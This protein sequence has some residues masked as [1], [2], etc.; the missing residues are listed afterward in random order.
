M[1]FDTAIIGAGPA[2]MQAACD[3]RARELSVIVLDEQP[4]PGGQ[5]WRGVERNC[6]PGS[7][8][9]QRLGAEYR[10][11]AGVARSFRAC[12]A[13]YRPLSRVWQIE[14]TGP[15]AT[16]Q[17]WQ[18]FVIRE[19]QAEVVEA[20]RVLLAIGAQERPVPFPGWTH[21][22]V[23]TVG[24]AQIMLKSGG[25][26]PEGPVWICG[27]GPLPLLYAHQLR[28]LGGQIAGFLDTA[29]RDTV[30]RG[31][32]HLS[33][34]LRDWKSLAKGLAWQA[35]LRAA[36][37]R[38]ETGVRQLRAE[39][40]DRL[41]RIRWETPEGEKTAPAGVLLIH[42][43]LVPSVHPTL[44]L[45][46]EHTWSDAQQSLRPVLDAWGETTRRGLFVA[47]D[48][49]GIDGARAALAKG[50]LAAVG[51]ARSLDVLSEAKAKQAR[52][53]GDRALSKARATRPLLD[54]LYPAPEGKI[55]DDVIVCRC[56]ELTAGQIRAAAGRGSADPN[57]V[58]S[59]TRAGMGPCQG[60]Q[61]GYT[62]ARLIAEAHDM[63]RAEVGF[64]NIRPPLKP[65][66]VG[67][68]ASL[69]KAKA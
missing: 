36:G 65:V 9:A 57:R 52:A 68:L 18:V 66:S 61:C 46:C 19:G 5:I 67:E 59:E 39:G 15:D 21:P 49:A 22:G 6:Q 31:L 27:A 63:P 26:L 13:D 4:A 3:L 34:A 41:E 42:E 43:G 8:L 10:Q 33:G 1:I 16:E 58:K 69:G 50:T 28:K 17:C 35:G 38:R 29:P 40:K 60:R 23:M 55:S 37:L 30:R 20:R 51:I 62:V 53:A 24:A 45:Q 12:G 44:S 32:P 47:G 25:L 7:E 54:T 64:H 48:A 11:G 56:E 14:E 2:G